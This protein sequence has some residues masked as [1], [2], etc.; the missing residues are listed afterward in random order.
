MKPSETWKGCFEAHHS[1]LRPGQCIRTARGV[2]TI[3][4]ILRRN[5]RG[6]PG[7]T[8][9]LGNTGDTIRLWDTP[10]DKDGTGGEGIWLVVG[11][12]AGPS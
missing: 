8:V 9:T 1:E 4:K 3:A 2:A 12:T 10:P 7:V 11:E 5:S 6:Q